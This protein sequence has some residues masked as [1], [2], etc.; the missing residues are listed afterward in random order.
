MENQNPNQERDIETIEVETLTPSDE[1]KNLK[2]NNKKSEEVKD[3]RKITTKK[4]LLSDKNVNKKYQS[5]RDLET[6]YKVLNDEEYFDKLDNIIAI[7]VNASSVSDIIIIDN[8]PYQ[9]G[10]FVTIDGSGLQKVMNFGEVG[11]TE[12]Y[13][14]KVEEHETLRVLTKDFPTAKKIFEKNEFGQIVTT[15]KDVFTPSKLKSFLEDLATSFGQTI[16]LVNVVKTHHTINDIQMVCKGNEWQIL[17][18]NGS[19]VREECYLLNLAV[20]TNFSYLVGNI[21]VAE[22]DMKEFYQGFFF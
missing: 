11:I 15:S 22:L 16:N 14:S 6:Y 17:S 9:I 5:L 18:Q 10:D 1:K 4:I 19:I 3:N 20:D 13:M 8:V 7:I 12:F 21:N 2:K